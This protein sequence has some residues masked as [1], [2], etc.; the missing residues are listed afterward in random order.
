MARSRRGSHTRF[1]HV[2]RNTGKR[3]R[4]TRRRL[5]ERCPPAK[6]ESQGQTLSSHVGAGRANT[7]SEVPVESCH[8]R[9]QP[10]LFPTVEVADPRRKMM[11]LLLVTSSSSQVTQNG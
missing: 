5:V 6:G 4:G 11:P 1:S 7:R 9:A 10:A 3:M 8:G 2:A